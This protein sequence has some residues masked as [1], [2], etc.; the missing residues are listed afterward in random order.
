M[1]I[2]LILV[3]KVFQ[4]SLISK[5]NILFVVAPVLVLRMIF[6][7]SDN[8]CM[9]GMKSEAFKLAPPTKAPFTFATPN[10]P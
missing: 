10:M 7:L 8:A 1:K 3:N 2:G 5:M 9:I 6:Q 4:F